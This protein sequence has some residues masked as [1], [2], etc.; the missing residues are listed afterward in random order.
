MSAAQI[1]LPLLILRAVESLVYFLL[2]L[3]AVRRRDSLPASALLSY[4]GT[5]F[6]IH[7][8][9][10]SGEFGWLTWLDQPARQRLDYYGAILLAL[11]LYRTLLIFFDKQRNPSWLTGALVWMALVV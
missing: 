2:V 5:A 4:V 7:L 9:R 11:L 6:F 1:E 10:I 8:L 3:L